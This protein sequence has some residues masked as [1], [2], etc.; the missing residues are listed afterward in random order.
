[1]RKAL[2]LILALVLCLSLCA[3]GGGE[4]SSE[5]QAPEKIP[6]TFILGKWFDV[7]DEVNS[8]QFNE[9]KSAVMTT[10]GG[11]SPLKWRYDA[12]QACYYIIITDHAGN[13]T[14]MP[15]S[16]ETVDGIEQFV[17]DS[18]TFVRKTAQDQQNATTNTDNNE[19]NTP[20]TDTETG[21]LDIPVT[22]DHTLLHPFLSE[23]YGEWT[24]DDSLS[25]FV[26]PTKITFYEDGT[27]HAEL[28]EHA[29]NRTMDLLWGVVPDSIEDWDNLYIRIGI[30]NDIIYIF[31]IAHRNGHIANHAA[32]GETDSAGCPID[33]AIDGLS[34][35][36]Y[37]G[38]WFAMK[39]P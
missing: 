27:C 11:D 24:I 12:E 6:E 34:E 3:C 28:P 9:D 31:H 13:S 4:Q 29:E 17:F 25:G 35:D 23:L 30:E 32:V 1:M 2:S 14:E 33:I 19:G 21:K 10:H 15:F 36:C 37:T 8:L 18:R 16:L 38:M 22:Y 20:A 7:S 39:K 5:T 26:V